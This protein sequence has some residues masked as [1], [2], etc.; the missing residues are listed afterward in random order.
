MPEDRI[1]VVI[2]ARHV[3]ASGANLDRI[4]GVVDGAADLSTK[5]TYALH[6]AV[7]NG[8]AVRPHRAD[9]RNREVRA[10]GAA[11]RLLDRS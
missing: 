1:V 7:S 11:E 4:R 6:R 9:R 3:R 8:P 5:P 2:A 10:P